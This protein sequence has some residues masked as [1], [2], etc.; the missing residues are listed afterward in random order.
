[1]SEDRVEIHPFAARPSPRVASA[2]RMARRLHQ[3]WRTF[4]RLIGKASTR[5]SSAHGFRNKLRE[6]PWTLREGRDR[7]TRRLKR[8]IAAP[9]PPQTH[10]ERAVAL[11]VQRTALATVLHIA[12]IIPAC[13]S[14]DGGAI[15]IALPG[16][17]NEM[18]SVYL[19]DGF[20]NLH[21]AMVIDWHPLN[22]P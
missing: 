1:M 19:R 10:Q 7:L 5:L 22:S 20:S 6:C 16:R 17:G 21:S 2:R 8:M 9:P 4:G 11:A 15:A 14:M 13:V 18:P 3:D 12:S